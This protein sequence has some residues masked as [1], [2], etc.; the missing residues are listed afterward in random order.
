MTFTTNKYKNP[1]LDK[2]YHAI[3]LG[4]I[5]DE[6]SS[7]TYSTVQEL[8]IDT[9]SK[10]RDSSV[11]ELEAYL[12]KFQGDIHDHVLTLMVSAYRCACF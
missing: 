5:C 11:D 4:A 6:L 9:L 12:T 1:D 3:A 7:A 10:I 2:N 8:F